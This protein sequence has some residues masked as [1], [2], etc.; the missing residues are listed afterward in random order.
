MPEKKSTGLGQFVKREHREKREPKGAPRERKEKR[1]L[2]DGR[3]QML[4]YLQPEG[5][6]QLKRIGVEEER[7]G[8]ELVAEAV[9]QWFQKRGLPPVA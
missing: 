2:S 4:V 3:E 6:K 5:I 9:N 8:S 7:S 1:R